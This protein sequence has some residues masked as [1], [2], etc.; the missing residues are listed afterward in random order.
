MQSWT[1]LKRLLVVGY[2]LLWPPFLILL[3]RKSFQADVFGWWSYRV[4][5]LLMSILVVLVG[6]SALVWR[7]VRSD[8]SK[9]IWPA[10]V[11]AVVRRS[12]SLTVL[13]ALLPVLVWLGV[14]IYAGIIRIDPNW[15]LLLSLA[16]LALLVFVW[17]LGLIF[18]ELPKATQRL[19]LMKCM[20]ATF[21]IMVSIVAIE[22]TAAVLQLS[23]YAMWELNHKNLNVRFQ[24]DDFD[25]KVVTNDQG[26]RE[27]KTVAADHPGVFRVIVVGDSMTFGWGAQYSEAYPQVVQN[28]L[29]EKYGLKNVEVINMGKPGSTPVD[30]LRYIRRYAAQLKPDLIVVGFLIGNDC[31]VYSPAS[32][33]NEEQVPRGF[34]KVRKTNE[35]KRGGTF[36][37]EVLP[38]PNFLYRN[39]SAVGVLRARADGRPSRA[40]IWRTEPAGPCTVRGGDRSARRSGFCSTSPRQLEKT[41]LVRKRLVLEG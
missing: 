2:V 26:L 5:G 31:P 13:A 36:I 23:P 18:S 37:V 34:G 40:F 17:E 16:D 11:L 19:R 4:F 30:Y 35:A 3:T 28:E 33:Q 8:D 29:R 6:L 32:L 10:R 24:T 1:C 20:L 39:L 38:G 41:G 27:P 21:A 7:W 25:V 15:K 22:I 9:T 14:I 12:R